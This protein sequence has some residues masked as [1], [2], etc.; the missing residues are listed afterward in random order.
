VGQQNWQ[1]HLAPDVFQGLTQPADPT[2][3]EP[4]LSA[5]DIESH[6]EVLLHHYNPLVQ[7]V[8]LYVISQ[9]DSSRAQK[10]A[11]DLQN[12]SH[13][14]L[15]GTAKQ[16][17]TAP[18]AQPLAQFTQLEELVYLAN[19]D[20][21]HRMEPETLIALSD[22][23]EVKPYSTGDVISDAGDTCRELLLLI[24]GRVKIQHQTE[25]GIQVNYLQPGKLLDEL[26]VLTHSNL[27]NTIIADSETTRV[28]TI[29]VDAFDDLLE[30]YPDVAPRV[31]ELESRY[32]QQLVGR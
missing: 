9:I 11:T 15:K 30:R 20:L 16:I 13:P 3:T 27:E 18:T 24:E 12:G 6:L 2:A 26:E 7:A 19:T 4:E 29:P 10:L 22:H 14:L 32:L 31:M 25:D 5:Q 28:L 1:N 21:F 23:A 17:L 8:T